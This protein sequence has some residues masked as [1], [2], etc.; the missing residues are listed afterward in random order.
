MC[1]MRSQIG[2]AGVDVGISSTGMLGRTTIVIVRGSGIEQPEGMLRMSRC[3][4]WCVAH[5][6]RVRV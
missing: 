4:E 1:A 2:V 6:S 5:G 3:C